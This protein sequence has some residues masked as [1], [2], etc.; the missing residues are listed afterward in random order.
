MF[1]NIDQRGN[2]LDRRK[3]GG[4]KVREGICQGGYV[5]GEMSRGECPTRG[6]NANVFGLDL[7]AESLGT[8]MVLCIFWPR[9][10]LA[11]RLTFLTQSYLAVFKIDPSFT[12]AGSLLFRQTTDFVHLG[13]KPF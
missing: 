12:P 2:V 1:S 11:W 4:G 9:C 13:A 6:L 5:R 3:A 7:E 8:V 10:S